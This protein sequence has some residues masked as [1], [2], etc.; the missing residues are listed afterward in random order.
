M[1]K[2]KKS[3]VALDYLNEKSDSFKNIISDV[4]RVEVLT[5]EKFKICSGS[6]E[7]EH[8]HYG[9]DGLAIHTAEVIQLMLSANTTLHCSVCEEEIFIAGLFHDLGKVWDYEKIQV[10]V[11]GLHG[12]VFKWEWQKTIHARRVHHISRSA[13][14]W[15]LCASKYGLP[16]EM[17]ENVLHAILSHHGSREHGSPVAPHTKLSWLLH[18]CDNLS[19]RMDD[20]T[21]HDIIKH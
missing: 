8:H 10:A 6:G 4:A 12:P 14:E 5:N 2:R 18:L 21:K 20:C 13:I 11:P 17:T 3:K 1:K 7:R 9:D 15:S 19:A 16:K